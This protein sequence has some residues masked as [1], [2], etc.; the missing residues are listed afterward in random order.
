[1]NG[2][3][4]LR[5]L[6]A[7]GLVA[8]FAGRALGCPACNIHNYLAKSVQSSTHIYEGEVLR[9]VSRTEAEV[10]VLK[11][12]RGDHKVG[13]QINSEMFLSGRYVGERFLF[14]N[15]TSEEP[16]FEALPP[17]FEDEV[18]FLIQKEPSV[19]D[20]REAVKRVQ[21]ISVVTQEIGMKYIEQH[22]D[23]AL[24]PL[25]AELDS[26]MPRVFS[27][28]ET[29]FGEHRLG[30]LVEA[31]LLKPTDAGREFVFSQ[32][33]ALP[34]QRPRPVDWV[35]WSF[36]RIIAIGLSFLLAVPVWIA[37]RALFRRWFPHSPR[38]RLVSLTAAGL[39]LLGT[40]WFLAPWLDAVPRKASARG[41]FLREMLGHTKRDPELSNA[42]KNRLLD[43]C[44]NLARP[45]LAETIYAMVLANMM[46]PDEVQTQLGG[47]ISANPAA[48][49]LYLAGNYESTLWQHEEARAMWNEARKL[50]EQG[51]LKAAIDMRIAESERKLLRRNR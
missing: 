50:A 8:F 47:L 35:R 15:P 14:S 11:V 25:L 19:G 24:E 13:S 3:K 16:R 7:T 51:D 2:A 37:A 9:Q 4:H 20:M 43:A 48:I 6:A 31:I 18:L 28:Q 21:G 27:G 38:S 42:V 17:E 45:I 44:P 30:K 49:G 39:A 34:S 12:L 41:V 32:I 5:F 26:L 10:R 23:A 40:A 36:G 1:M 33:D 29:F 22:H 46:R